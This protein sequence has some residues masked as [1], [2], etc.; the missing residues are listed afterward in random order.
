MK[1]KKCAEAMGKGL[2]GGRGDV[3]DIGKVVKGSGL[4]L[5]HMG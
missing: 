3:G 4:T 1:A 5:T 2:R